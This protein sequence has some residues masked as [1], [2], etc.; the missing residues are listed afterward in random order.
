MVR[1]RARQ[2]GLGR[3][4]LSRRLRS[5]ICGR[6]NRIGII[7]LHHIADRNL[8]DTQFFCLRGCAIEQIIKSG[9]VGHG[10]DRARVR[11]EIGLKPFTA[12]LS[13][14]W[15]AQRQGVVPVGV[16]ADQNGQRLARLCP[17]L[18]LPSDRRAVLKPDGET[19]VCLAQVIS[20]QHNDLVI[21]GRVGRVQPMFGI[22]R[23]IRAKARFPIQP[24]VVIRRPGREERDSIFR[25][26][27]QR[28]RDAQEKRM[29]DA[30]PKRPFGQHFKSCR[31]R[32]K[33]HINLFGAGCDGDID[34]ARTLV[35]DRF[36]RPIA[37]GHIRL[38]PGDDLIRAAQCAQ[39]DFLVP[40]RIDGPE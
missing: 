9:R 3:L 19:R 24:L 38:Q 29:F 39:S 34:L 11:C 31:M 5:V 36:D 21:P 20:L 40:R 33:W 4:G 15:G 16:A 7:P 12:N 22:A 32:R 14:V 28:V 8:P 13:A 10:Q 30:K 6:G 35:T 37:Q 25:I 2:I 17:C 26:G 27:L 23:T 18:A 1:P